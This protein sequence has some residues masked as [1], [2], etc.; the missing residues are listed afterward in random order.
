[1][2][3]IDVLLPQSGMGMQ[4]AEIVTWLKSIGD[5]ISEGEILVE[6]EAAKVAI[7]VPS[8]VSGKVVRILAL[9]GEVVEVREVIAKIQ[10]TA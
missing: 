9:E 7:D 8:P 10:E 6:V 1:M 4:D 3:V 5:D 2:A